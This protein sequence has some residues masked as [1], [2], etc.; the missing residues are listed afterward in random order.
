[1]W[2]T[3][4]ERGSRRGAAHLSSRE[5]RAP[6]HVHVVLLPQVT[7]FSSLVSVTLPAPAG[8]MRSVA[9]P[10]A[11][12]DRLQNG[13]YAVVSVGKGRR[14]QSG[15]CAR[16]R[17]GRQADR[18]RKFNRW[19]SPEVYVGCRNC[20]KESRRGFCAAA[21]LA[22]DNKF[23]VAAE[24]GGNEAAVKIKARRAAAGAEAHHSCGNGR[25]GKVRVEGVQ[26]AS[27]E[28]KVARHSP[29]EPVARASMARGV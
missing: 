21:S 18:A 27:R 8:N 2:E 24:R 13:W 17:V 26:P 4:F 25:L 14:K 23:H 19:C 22:N 10:V 1:M 11:S 6:P 15:R 28:I 20:G 7:P 16:A 5:G 12:I 29:P 9:K 3:G